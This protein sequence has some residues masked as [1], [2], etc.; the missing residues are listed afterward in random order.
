MSASPTR[1]LLQSAAIAAVK[2]P[3]L[4]SSALTLMIHSWVRLPPLTVGTAPSPRM[5]CSAPAGPR[6]SIQS[7]MKFGRMSNS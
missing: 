1:A 2:R 3:T 7:S 6:E 5:D 4:I